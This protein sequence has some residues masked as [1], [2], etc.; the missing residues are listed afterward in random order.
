MIKIVD[1]VKSIYID[2]VYQLNPLENSTTYSEIDG[3]CSL[4]L[5]AE[6]HDPEKYSL[7]KGLRSNLDLKKYYQCRTVKIDL[8]G[9]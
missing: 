1:R 6:A 5:L 7:S 2:V 3:S 8:F 9:W 4:L